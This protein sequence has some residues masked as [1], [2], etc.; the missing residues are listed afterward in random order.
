VRVDASGDY[1][2]DVLPGVIVF[3][4]GL[5][6]TVAPLTATVLAGAPAHHSGIASGVNNAV[7]RVAGLLAV[8]VVGAVCAAQFSSAIDS[9]LPSSGLAPQTQHAIAEAKK[10]TLVTDAGAAAAADRPRVH[11]ALESASVKSYRLGIAIAGLL[12]IAGGLISLAGL[13]P[14]PKA[15]VHPVK[16]ECCPGGAIVGASE[17]VRVGQ[18]ADP[19]QQPVVTPTG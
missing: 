19:A 8:A 15:V 17:E 7:A 6:M 18:M 1:V 13:E 16:A 2:K 9:H 3:G 11:A 4:L 14:R 10:R 12:A 5:S